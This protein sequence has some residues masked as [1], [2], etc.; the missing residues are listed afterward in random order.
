MG[1][2]KKREERQE[3]GEPSDSIRFPVLTP[4]MLAKCPAV[5]IMLVECGFLQCL[6][7]SA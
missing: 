7:R 1:S 5:S 4:I 6:N 2:R 3:F